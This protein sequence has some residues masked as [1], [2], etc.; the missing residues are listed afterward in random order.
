M[1]AGFATLLAT[2]ED[3]E[4]V[5]E[6]ANGEEAVRLVAELRPD[7]ALLD[8]RMPEMNGIQATAAICK[9]TGGATKVLILTTFDLDDY[10]FDALAAGASGFLLKDA[11]FPELLNAVRVVAAGKAM[12]APDITRRLIAEFAQQRRPPV[13]APST[14]S[15]PVKRKFCSSSRR[16]CPTWTSHSSSRFR[17]TP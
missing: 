8:I 7:L 16:A 4:V 13:P 15:P 6:A 10:V 14:T 2:Q 3:I 12:L 9:E 11:T 17:L 1:R 5:G